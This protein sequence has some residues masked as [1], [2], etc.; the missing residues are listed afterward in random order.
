MTQRP[1]AEGDLRLWSSVDRYFDGLLNLPDPDLEAA[2]AASRESGLPDIQ[3]SALQGKF[4]QLLARVQGARRI[5]EIGTLGG[6]SAIWLGR[7]LPP[8]G[9]MISIE[10]SPKHAEIARTNLTRAGLAD[11]VE[12]VVG[13]ALEILPQLIEKRG[14]PFDLTFIDADKE[15]YPAYLEWARQLSRRGSL[16][17]ADN[18][19]RRG[20]VVDERSPDPNVQGVRRM[21]DILGRDPRFSAT[22]IQTVGVKGHDGLAIAVVVAGPESSIPHRT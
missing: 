18:V 17:L 22:V 21:N 5:L 14:E 4:L 10:L 12:V 13:P 1:S 3:V 19:V 9:R 11:K 15:N 20:D 16:I 6:Y 7:A 8:E 2:L